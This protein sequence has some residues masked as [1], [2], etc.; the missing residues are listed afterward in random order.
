MKF[1][2]SSDTD[3]SLRISVSIRSVLNIDETDK[4]LLPSQMHSVGFLLFGLRAR[5]FEGLDLETSFLVAE[6]LGQVRK[7]RS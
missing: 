4:R 3:F 2:R 6:Y 7:S 1:Y 5:T